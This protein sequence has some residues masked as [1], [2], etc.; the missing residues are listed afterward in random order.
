MGHLK[1]VIEPSSACEHW[2]DNSKFMVNGALRIRAA[3]AT[4]DGIPRSDA[5]RSASGAAF[6]HERP[7]L[8]HYRRI[9]AL[10]RLASARFA[11]SPVPIAA[12][13]AGN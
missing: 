8:V 2:A 6:A 10:R 3:P 11:G 9:A 12:E 13:A 7:P 1:I 4:G 5:I